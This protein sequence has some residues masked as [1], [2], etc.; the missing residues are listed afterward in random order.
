LELR[1][2]CYRLD[3]GKVKSRLGNYQLFLILNADFMMQDIKIP[4]IEEGKNW[5]RAIDTSLSS[6]EDFPDNGKETLLNPSDHYLVNPRSTVV[7]L[8]G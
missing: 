8:G 4:P 6:S 5:Y 1:T 2:L 7:L 3:G